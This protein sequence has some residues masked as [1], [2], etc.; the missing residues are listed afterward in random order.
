[1]WATFLAA[2]VGPLAKKILLALGIG[3]ITYTGLQAAFDAASAQVVA[4]YGSMSGGSLAIADLAGV[5]QSIGI[6]LGALS[7]R[8]A[9]IVL[10][11]FVKLT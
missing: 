9:M 10:A 3:T 11:R 5:G 2:A 8:L 4:N 6:V 7:A 1:M